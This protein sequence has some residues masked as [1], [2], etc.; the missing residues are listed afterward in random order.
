MKKAINNL[1]SLTWIDLILW[2]SPIIVII[3]W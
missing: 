2:A 1:K 3:L